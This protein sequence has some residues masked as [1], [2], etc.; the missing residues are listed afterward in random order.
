[1]FLISNEL[2]ISYHLRFECLQNHLSYADVGPLLN[3]QKLNLFEPFSKQLVS[4]KSK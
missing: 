1:M 2:V 4:C 3:L